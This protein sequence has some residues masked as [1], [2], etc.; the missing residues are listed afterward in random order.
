[1]LEPAD[2]P[3]Y[4]YR[5]PICGERMSETDVDDEYICRACESVFTIIYR[6]DGDE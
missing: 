5:C 4:Y 2:D 3:E 6:G 1:M